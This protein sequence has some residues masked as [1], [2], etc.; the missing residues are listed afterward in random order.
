MNIPIKK[1]SELSEQEKNKLFNRRLDLDKYFNVVKEI[2]ENVK[3]RGDKALLEYT[4]KFDG[5]Q[6]KNLEVSEQ[7]FKEARSK[8][9][10]NVEST[11]LACIKNIKK[12]HLLQLRKTE[13]I[14]EGIEL[15]R[16]F[17]PLQAIGI[18]VPG[19]TASY[20]STVIMA[21]IP[22][23]IAGVKDIVICTPPRK[24]CTTDPLVLLAAK[25]C[26][27]NKIY[28]VGGAQAIAALAYGTESIKK[29]DKIVGPGNVYVTA[30]KLLVSKDV[31]IDFPCG[32]SE[33]LAIADEKA[34][35]ELLAL[36]LLAQAEHDENAHA[37]LV[38]TSQ[39]IA[40]E[41]KVKLLEL[42]ENLERKAIILRA[43][44]SNSAILI[45]RS[46]QECIE[47]ANLYAPEHLELVVSK[48]VALGK[49]K[50][51]GSVFLGESTPSVVGDYSSGSNHILPTSGYARTRSALSADDFV[52]SITYQKISKKALF[53]LAEP[54]VRVARL[55]GFEAHAK[56]LEKRLEKWKKRGKT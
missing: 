2:I 4:A 41:V 18:Y 45:A 38:T 53:T 54:A 52:K 37:V 43:L 36:D 11:L 49:I 5:A 19:G 16:L 26:K 55:E 24:D 30:A 1:L 22:A 8:I 13:K 56:S 51:A 9:P 34:D 40:N 25:L 27:V 32:P 48:P 12:F 31:D 10:K 44:E 50:T 39:K 46:I 47:F 7:E 23:K 15:G 35:S 17:Q 33:I 14:K 29:V 21:C 42:I 20:P 3:S 6:L 28:K